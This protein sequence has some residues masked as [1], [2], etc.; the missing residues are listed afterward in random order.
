VP[1]A[2]ALF[3]RKAAGFQFKLF[4]FFLA[5]GF[6]TDI[7]MYLML[8]TRFVDRLPVIFNCYSLVEAL[9]FLLLIYL[10][11]T[12][13]LM[14]KGTGVL[15]II[16]VLLW[17]TVVLIKPA[18]LQSSA[19]QVFD[20][21]YEVVVAFLAGFTLLQLVEQQ[22][23]VID[24]PVFWIFLGMFFYCFCTFFLMGLVNTLISQRI[25]IVNNIVNILTY[26]L[27]SIGVWKL[28]P[29]QSAT[30]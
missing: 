30:F 5:V 23:D 1:L 27:Y 11:A 22:P 9:T 8:G 21:F 29:L 18:F 3:N 17:I 24:S 13:K 20:L 16:T 14:K 15:L 2:I 19:S 7:T 4:I 25:W 10:N 28:R 6:A 26:M 12:G